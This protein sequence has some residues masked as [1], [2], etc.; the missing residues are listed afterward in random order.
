MAF[1][2][3]QRNLLEGLLLGGS[4]AYSDYTYDEY[5]DAGIDYSGNRLK[6]VPKNQYSLF[7][8]YRHGSGFGAAAPAM[9]AAPA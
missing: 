7:A 9:S 2:D 8:S 3:I 6:Y 1:L 4:Y 5:V